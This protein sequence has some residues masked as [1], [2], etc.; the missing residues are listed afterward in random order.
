[1]K[2]NLRKTSTWMPLIVA[3]AL[4]CGILLGKILPSGSSSST[5]AQQKIAEMMDIISNLYVDDVDTDSLL[6]QSMADIMSKLDPHSVYIAAADLNSVNEEL[7]GSFSGIG[8]T[9]TIMADTIT[10]NEVISGG[11]AERV[12]LM[13]GDRIVT[14]NDSV[15]VGPSWPDKRVL[16]TLRGQKGTPV[17]LGI[18]RSTAPGRLLPFTVVRDDIPVTTID[19]S[20][21]IN[22]TTG[23]IRVNKFGRNTF[24]EF[25][26]ELTLLANQG[27][28]RFIIDLR[29]NTGGFL[30][31]ANMMANE[32]LPAGAT[33]VSMHGRTSDSNSVFRANG[34][35][36][37]QDA[38]VVVL[39]DEYSA[40]SSEIFAGA[41]QDN[42]RGLVI[43]RRSFGKGLVQRQLPLSDS[44]ALRITT[45]R[46]YTPSGRCIQKRYTLGDNESYELDIYER[47]N[48]GES[49]SV[50]SIQLDKSVT[51]YTSTGR[52]VYGGGGIMPDIFVPLDT[53]G[54]S[55][56]Y[57][58]VVNAGLLQKFAFSYADA[59]RD[60]L[61]SATDTSE[62][63]SKLP[64]DSEL[65]ST[66]VAYASRSAGVPAQW[67]YINISRDLIVKQLKALI[68]R[69]ILGLS[70]YYE[71]M[72][73]SD[74]AVARALEEMESGNLKAPILPNTPK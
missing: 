52:E 44:S 74:P 48:H 27:A 20:Y 21:L 22:P 36:S 62:L 45:A 47:L 15:A 33:I 73:L 8:V 60:L 58:N 40:S 32:F 39:L 3:A 67:Y 42:D 64:S 31:I 24:D 66:F 29:G 28:K 30:E 18:K 55:K 14:I 61:S 68:A 34:Q 54:Y 57:F 56:Y 50:D 69:D 71:V 43:G 49:L 4:I 19:A 5:P 35:G 13:P 2:P 25:F 11:P 46:Y 23:F 12:G 63:L 65:L 7:E 1:M 26:T 38:E 59:A 37:F 9:F 51:F 10:I 70:G 72:N 6:E 41:I 17:E 53:L 16:S